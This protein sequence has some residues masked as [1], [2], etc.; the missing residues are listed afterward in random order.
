M[1]ISLNLQ[2]NTK[3]IDNLAGPEESE[4][5][6]KKS[7]W[8]LGGALSEEE[9]A[10]N[11]KDIS[12]VAWMIIIGDALHNV[13]DGLAIG[14][15]FSE[16]GASG[17]SGGMST[18][19]AVFCHELPHELGNCF[20]KYTLLS[21]HLP[22]APRYKLNRRCLQTNRLAF[23]LIVSKRRSLSTRRNMCSKFCLKMFF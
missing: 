8:S 20:Q 11:L 1:F 10:K 12:T 5:G 4:E 7:K 19:I 2:Q 16:G 3:G 9:G 18:S 21:P 15:A 6:H 14:A 13:G 23:R 22:R 17:I